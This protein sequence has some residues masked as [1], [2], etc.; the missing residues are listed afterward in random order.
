M[1]TLY[2]RHE[3]SCRYKK[4][5][6]RHVGCSCP[7]WMDGYDIRAVR[8]RRSLRTRS[9]SQAQIR[10]DEFE[11]GKALREPD[12]SIAL[13]DAVESYLADC[14]AR[15]LQ[16][17][18]LVSY[19]NTLGHLKK[20]FPGSIGSVDLAKLTAFRA[21]RKV[22]AASSAKEIQAFR[23]FFRFCLE[24]KWITENP[25]KAL[26]PPKDDGLPTMPFT[27]EEIGKILAACDRIDN[28]N[29]REIPRARIRALALV[30]LLLYSGFRISDAVKLERARV[31]RDGRLLVRL[32]KT[33]APLYL[34]L[35]V[36]ALNALWAIPEES[37]Y[38]LWSGTAKLSTAIGSAR[39]TIACVLKL[40]GIEGH[41]HMFRDTF[42]VGL[43]REGAELRTVQL[44]L[45]HKSIRTTEKH[46][47]PFV[48]SMQRILDE[49]VSKLHFSTGEPLGMDPK[50]NTLRDGKLRIL[51]LPRSKRA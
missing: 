51:A 6:R 37:E 28:P 8:Q 23:T 3:D 48:V 49:A 17:S 4:K 11:N 24:R 19:T 47:A 25:A 41:P 15:R 18:T 38:F 39:R 16:P 22:T 27:D 50:H 14:K 36:V 2:R 26:R 32:M 33:R 42:A 10:L 40:A 12:S 45:G 5:G 20:A 31:E 43:L 46:Y 35:P 7:V 34:R 44:L 9:W 13:S 30:L 29:Q 21:G 1:Y